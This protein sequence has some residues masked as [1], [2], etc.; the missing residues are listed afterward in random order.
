MIWLMIHCVISFICFG[1]MVDIIKKHKD[2]IT[3]L[4]LFYVI[5]ISVV[6]FIN[7]IVLI[8]YFMTKL[9]N[10]VVWRKK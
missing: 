5:F 7:T 10:A 9:D 4:E 1:M 3:A 6:P 8:R 2:E